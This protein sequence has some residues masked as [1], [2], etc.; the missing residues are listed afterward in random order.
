MLGRLAGRVQSGFKQVR[1]ET[2]G[3]LLW[4]WWWTC[5]F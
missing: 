1:I 3:G 5:G 2:S 4:K